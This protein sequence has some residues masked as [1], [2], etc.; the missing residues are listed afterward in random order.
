MF[1]IEYLIMLVSRR[2]V[3]GINGGLVDSLHGT[4]ESSMNHVCE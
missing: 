1:S 4:R 2:R 3:G